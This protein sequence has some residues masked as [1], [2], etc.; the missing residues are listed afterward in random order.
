MSVANL[1]AFALQQ[2]L[3]K[4]FEKMSQGEQTMLRYQYLMQAT[5]DAQ[6]DFAR[7]SDGYANT[8]RQF[9]TN[10]QSLKT[11]MGTILLPVVNDVIAG[12]NNLVSSF[13][14]VPK[15]TI[16]DDFADMD[17]KLDER[18]REINKT[19]F[20]AQAL[21]G[22][23]AST[24]AP[25]DG[26]NALSTF[27]STLSASFN[28][29]DSALEKAQTNDYKG[30]LSEIAKALSIQLGGDA[31]GWETLLDAIASNLPDVSKA[32]QEDGGTSAAFLAA[33]AKS[34]SELGAGYDTRWQ[35]L[36][37]ALGDNG[38]T[39]I[40]ALADGKTAAGAMDEIAKAAGDLGIL[41]PGRWSEMLTTL[42]GAETLKTVFGAESD[43]IT[44]RIGALAS[45]LTGNAPSEATK[46]AWEGLLGAL[47]KNAGAL[48]EWRGED[49]ETTKGWLSGLAEAAAKL[50]PSD[51]AG[52]DALFATLTTNL[53][54]AKTELDKN[55]ESVASGLNT[56]SGEAKRTAPGADVTTAWKTLIDLLS[57]DAEA[58][59]NLTG[60]TP[61][62]V[63]DWL[64]VVA[65]GAN[66][67]DPNDADAW[68]TLFDTLNAGIPGLEN[69]EAGQTF[70]SALAAAFGENGAASYLAALGLASDGSAEQ[71]S[72]LLRI[73]QELIRTIPGLSEIINEETGE[74]E[75][76]TAAL[77]EYVEQWRKANEQAA[78]REVIGA[79]QSVLDREKERLAGL[80]D[81]LAYHE[82]VLDVL[83]QNI[84]TTPEGV[85]SLPYIDDDTQIKIDAANAALEDTTETVEK[86][87]AE[88]AA[89]ELGVNAAE[90][91]I[92]SAKMAIGDFGLATE[93]AAVSTNT[94][95]VSEEDAA[96]AIQST[97]DAM[98]E[99]LD[100]L[101]ETKRGTEQAVNS[102]ITG[103]GKITTPAEKAR[104]EM[105]KLKA[106]GLS[107][108][109]ISIR[110]GD[111]SVP[112]IQ[113]M[114]EG[115]KD[116]LYYIQ[117]YN[118]NLA[119]ARAKGISNDL[120]ATLSDG[121]VESA[122][123]LKALAGANADEVAQI[124]E[125]WAKVQEGKSTFVDALTAQKLAADS[126]FD[127]IVQKANDTV[128]ALDMA[129]GARDAMGLTVQG[130]A[131]GIAAQLPSVQTQ[132]AALNAILAQIN[133]FDGVSYLVGSSGKSSGVTIP[134]SIKKFGR[135]GFAEVALDGSLAVGL[136][137]V[138][139]D[140][141]LAALH[142]GEAILTAEEAR[143][144]RNFAYGQQSRA[145]TLDYD[146][147]GGL[148][149]DNV[150]AGGNVY[151]DGRTVGRVLSA[152]QANSYRALERSGWQ[153]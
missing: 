59:S 51:L 33:A 30:V 98:S 54:S 57:Q 109:E 43:D 128:T 146:A 150:R 100:Y 23:L 20:E 11:Q 87:R 35:K 120:L 117:E 126:T 8:I 118:R 94:L 139:F 14:T 110:M 140:N 34:A 103:F 12:V 24:S 101:N 106:E 121:G 114:V 89:V 13:T 116:Q 45:T 152:Q 80:K 85:N 138:P 76:G 62:E 36:L 72:Q 145:N 5:A 4:T 90:T 9:E 17:F 129:D 19:A 60:T 7:T 10:L 124:N 68:K 73:T 141:Y 22:A 38:A 130:I 18:L 104:E 6:G 75:G 2:G 108:S 137:Y 26:Q 125:A 93:G 61:D 69:S 65:K 105:A 28:G 149:R 132:V 3:S 15:R 123:Y 53:S 79:K 50:K 82:M 55:A 153:Q 37:A 84:L 63:K 70:L 39:A 107:G 78:K 49:V 58:L 102:I 133:G 1:N 134:G 25:G 86:L 32:A 46:T 97:T 136:D 127:A 112:T 52:W 74:I 71:Q 42:A 113:N 44:E 99:M 147:L 67:I 148:M 143:V 92:S 16:L 77:M 48:A 27:V 122:D 131:D 115:L 47:Y 21:I 135:G 83:R 111:S 142:E 29:L 96:K 144:W 95:V 56:I 31:S 119:F 66:A 64:N 151:L 91:Q 41:A 40:A 81:E 88:V